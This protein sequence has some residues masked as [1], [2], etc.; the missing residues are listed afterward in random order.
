LANFSGSSCRVIVVSD[1]NWSPALGRKE[2]L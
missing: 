2:T 1:E